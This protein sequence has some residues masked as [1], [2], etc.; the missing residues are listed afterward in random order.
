MYTQQQLC[1]TPL[2]GGDLD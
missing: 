1:L 2:S